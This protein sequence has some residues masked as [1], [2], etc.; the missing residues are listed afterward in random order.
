MKSKLLISRKL[1]AIY[2]N[3]R[4]LFLLTNVFFFGWFFCED[5]KKIAIYFSPNEGG[6][7]HAPRNY[8][9]RVDKDSLMLER[10][11]FGETSQ[12]QVEPV[13]NKG[14]N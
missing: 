2:K 14:M 10:I 12:E 4:L 5:Q 1:G 7:E 8:A 6:N 13:D 9:E 11:Y 3:N